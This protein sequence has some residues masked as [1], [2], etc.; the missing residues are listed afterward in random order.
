MVVVRE[1]ESATLSV[2]YKGNN[3][4]WMDAE[5]DYYIDYEWL[6]G[7]SN[8]TTKAQVTGKNAGSTLLTFGIEDSSDRFYVMVI[9]VK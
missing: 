2:T 5:K 3:T 9:V 8:D 4:I 7:W 1:G 6:H